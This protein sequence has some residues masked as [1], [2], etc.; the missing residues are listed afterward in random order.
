[1]EYRKLGRTG[2]EVSVIGL[3]TEYLDRRP[4][5]TVV[6]V[7]HE[8]I[9]RGVNY[10]DLLFAFPEYRDNFG[11]ALKGYRDRVL[12]AGH[13]RSAETNGQYRLTRDVKECEELFF[14]LLSRLDTDYVDILL[15][16]MVDEEEDYE[17]IM[18]A[19][20]LMELA[21]RF[22]QEGKARFIGMSG[23]NPSLALR[24]VEDGKIDVLMFPINAIGVNLIGSV[25]SGWEELLNA[26]I[27]KEV[28][29]VVMKP[30]A[31]GRLFEQKSLR[32]VTPVQ[33][34]NYVLSQEG[35]S[36]T[37]PGVKN[38]KE[39]KETLHFLEATDEEK[40][41]S[42]IIAHFEHLKGECT[43]CDH[44]LPCPSDIWIGQLIRLVDIAQDGISD[45]LQA[46]YN[47]L[48][49]KASDCIECGSCMER[50]PFG[51][52]VISK[53][54]QAVELFEMKV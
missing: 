8:A 19:G 50:C 41:F 27:S 2:L 33:C 12:I 10:F 22:Q 9:E 5:E 14:D 51:V 48:S 7:V 15:F 20:G 49:A 23:H 16:Q 26:C 54:R 52:D 34:L 21:L 44:C 32:S 53:M 24:A 46:E 6:S 17:E 45:D 30:F 42:S 35:V 36:T 40:D 28:G 31:G 29:L 43:Y 39:L 3:G 47:A 13:L 4:R 11:A 25:V 38:T 18:S 1:M 37:V